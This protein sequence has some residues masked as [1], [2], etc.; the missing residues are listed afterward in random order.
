MFDE[1]CKFGATNRRIQ[2]ILTADRFWHKISI[3][4]HLLKYELIN[5]VVN[6]GTQSLS[7]P[8]SSIDGEWT[9]YSY[10]MD[11]DLHHSIYPWSEVTIITTS[12]FDMQL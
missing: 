9:E 12:Y 3:P 8:W 1:R 11:T 6:M 2:F 5:K 10:H 7:I 4:N